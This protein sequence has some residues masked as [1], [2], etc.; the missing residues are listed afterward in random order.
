MKTIQIELTEPTPG[1]FNI[2]VLNSVEIIQGQEVCFE[3]IVDS[4]VSEKISA[5]KIDFGD[6][7]PV[8]TRFPNTNDGIIETI[9][10]V[11]QIITGDVSGLLL[12]FKHVYD[13]SPNIDPTISVLFNN[14][15][16]ML[17]DQATVYVR[18]ALNKLTSDS[19]L[20]SAEFTNNADEVIVA[21]R[22]GNDIR[23]LIL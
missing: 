22:D 4:V 13:A 5:I 3:F 20:I 21:L 17:S 23:Y 11:N 19:D 16:P 7:S 6:G 14:T 8:S 10:V 2:N 9:D 12:P 1:T 18:P 15:P